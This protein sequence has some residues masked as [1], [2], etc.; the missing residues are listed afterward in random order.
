MPKAHDNGW[1]ID[2]I[3]NCCS[4]DRTR[5][6]FTSVGKL[7]A[8]RMRVCYPE[9]RRGRGKRIGEEKRGRPRSVK[10]KRPAKTAWTA[11]PSRPDGCQKRKYT[12]G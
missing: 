11:V 10:R 3:T 5:C 9:K 4:K 1:A 12:G 8:A 7:G 2:S 6:C